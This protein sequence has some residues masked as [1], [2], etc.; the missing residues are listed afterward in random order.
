MPEKLASRSTTRVMIAT[1]PGGLPSAAAASYIGVAPKT[2]SNWR[3][4][5]EGP[6]YV[7]LGKAHA[8]IVYRVS[9]LDR[10][11]EERVVGGAR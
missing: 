11:L 4:L 5:G 7:R 3:A 9:D 1:S 10:Y 6:P 8:R 2:L